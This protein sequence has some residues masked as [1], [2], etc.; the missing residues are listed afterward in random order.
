MCADVAKMRRVTRSRNAGGS[1]YDRRPDTAEETATSSA[2]LLRACGAALVIAR[3]SGRLAFADRRSA[4]ERA[5]PRRRSVGAE[6][7]PIGGWRSVP[8]CCA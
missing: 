4:L 7:E 3:L 2:L 5:A 8:L 6:P 1:G